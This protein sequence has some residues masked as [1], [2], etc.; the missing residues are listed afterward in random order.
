[1][2]SF[3][4]DNSIDVSALPAPQPVLHAWRALK[5]LRSGQVLRVVASPGQT[6]QDFFDFAKLTGHTLQTEKNADG[7]M[8]LH[9]QKR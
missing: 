7:L 2:T 6:V 8:V 3:A 5:S 9:L 4:S 1:M